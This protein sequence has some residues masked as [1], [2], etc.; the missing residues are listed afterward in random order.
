MVGLFDRFRRDAGQSVDDPRK[1][2][3]VHLA[4][5]GAI[6]V[7]RGETGEQLWTD[8]AG[9][10][11]ELEHARESGGRLLYSREH[12]EREPSSAVEQTF[13]RILG[14]RIPIQLL[15]KPHPQALVPPEQRRTVMRDEQRP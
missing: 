15:D 14:Y 8:R 2:L 6:L 4:E 11:R 12:A 3:Y 1:A 10:E 7:I 13:K 5:D 9:L